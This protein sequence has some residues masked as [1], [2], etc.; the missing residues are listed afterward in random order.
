MSSDDG[1]LDYSVYD[2]NR[3]Q[4]ISSLHIYVYML[5]TY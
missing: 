5:L 3:S 4:N 1:W 2:E